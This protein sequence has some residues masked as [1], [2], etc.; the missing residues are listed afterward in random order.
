M[1]P[2]RRALMLQLD[3]LRTRL[4]PRVSLIVVL[5]VAAASVALAPEGER[6]GFRHLARTASLLLPVVAALGALQG[7]VSLA[8][9]VSSGALRCVLLHPLPR[10]RWVFAIASTLVAFTTLLYLS[11]LL[12]AAI[13]CGVVSGFGDVVFEGFV[14]LSEAEMVAYARRLLLLPL[15]PLMAAPLA[16]VLVSTLIEDVATAVMLALL[17]VLGPLLGRALL[18]AWPAWL[19]TEAVARP[20]DAL[21]EL[22]EGVTLQADAVERGSYLIAILGPGLAWCAALLIVSLVLWNRREVSV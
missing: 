6:P 14:V 20:V 5:I 22:A 3:L 8:G 4:L 7:A 1:R 10:S 12:V 9:D 17:V 13:G 11:G 2:Y 18:G 15:L 16:G 19:F 21:G